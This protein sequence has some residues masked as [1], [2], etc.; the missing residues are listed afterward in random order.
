MQGTQLELGKTCSGSLNGR[1]FGISQLPMFDAG[2]LLLKVSIAITSI[3][4]SFMDSNVILTDK[5]KETHCVILSL[6]SQ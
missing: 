5:K 6:V 4:V 2:E 1:N 3:T